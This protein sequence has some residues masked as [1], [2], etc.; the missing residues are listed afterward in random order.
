MKARSGNSF[1]PLHQKKEGNFLG[2]WRHRVKIKDVIENETNPVT[3]MGKEIAN[4][5][6]KEG[7]FQ[8]F[9]F[10]QQFNQVDSEHELDALLEK[11]YDFADHH[12][13]WIE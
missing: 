9:S 3:A 8:N 4:R 11:L 5:L 7:C 13:I 2:Q 12:R 6:S 10:R 1:H